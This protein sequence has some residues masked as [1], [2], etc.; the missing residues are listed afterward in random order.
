MGGRSKED[1]NKILLIGVQ[2]QNKRKWTQTETQ[3]KTIINGGWILEQIFTEVAMS[4]S[5]DIQ[6]PNGQ[7]PEK[8]ALV[9]HALS[10][11]WRRKMFYFFFSTVWFYIINNLSDTWSKRMNDHLNWKKIR[12]RKFNVTKRNLSYL[13]LYG[14]DCYKT[15]STI[16]VRSHRTLIIG[17][18]WAYR[19][20]K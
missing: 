18:H 16:T 1:G 17:M 9:D 3:R 14:W 6:N 11:N 5:E 7:Y 8:P 10:W 20:S 12:I 2:W 19:K 15:L 13:F 4:T